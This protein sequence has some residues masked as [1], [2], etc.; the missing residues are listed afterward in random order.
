MVNP[1]VPEGLVRTT[2]KSLEKEILL[3]SEDGRCAEFKIGVPVE[4]GRAGDCVN[5]YAV[6]LCVLGEW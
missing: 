4:S 2:T 5:T 3:G 6:E 1:E